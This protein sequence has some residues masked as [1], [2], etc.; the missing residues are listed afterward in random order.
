MYKS[1]PKARK[2]SKKRKLVPR[3]PRDPDLPKPTSFIDQVDPLLFTNPQPSDDAWEQELL[4]E[5]EEYAK[6]REPPSLP[7]PPSP[8]TV[9]KHAAELV[10]KYH[11]EYSYPQHKDSI[12]NFLE[13][14]KS[15]GIYGPK[16]PFKKPIIL[17]N[18][19]MIYARALYQQ[20]DLYFSFH[21]YPEIE[22]LILSIIEKILV[23]CSE[24]KGNRKSITLNDVKKA[25]RK[26]HLTHFTKR[27]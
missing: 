2:R 13:R 3:K 12:N 25:E 8:K 26:L 18:R 6:S 4:K 16:R 24:T 27:S 9:A 10:D 20:P 21:A 22:N 15:R 7:L 1:N 19:F 23:T 5:I 14:R 11:A 17:K